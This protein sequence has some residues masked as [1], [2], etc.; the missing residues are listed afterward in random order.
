[1]CVVCACMREEG[2]CVYVCA[3]CIWREGST[4][5][6]H[7][8][9]KAKFGFTEHVLLKAKFGTIEHGCHMDG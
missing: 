1:M 3:V 8:L 2:V 4:E 5:C 7:S 9:L 6:E